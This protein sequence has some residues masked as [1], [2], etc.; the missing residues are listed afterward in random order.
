MLKINL[1]LTLRNLLK[2]KAFAFINIAGLA[3]GIAIALLLYLYIRNELSFDQQQSQKNAIYRLIFNA[4]RDGVEEKWGCS[5]NIA[6]PVFKNE[7]PE[8]IEQV[9]LV[10]HNFGEDANIRFE[11]KAFYEKNL[12][13]VDSGFC[14]VFDLH[15]VAG[16]ATSSLKKPN[17]IIISESTSKKSMFRS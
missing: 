10:R 14:N 13:F 7:I 11:D 5:P 3:S 12:Y 15:F 8:I 4:K 2:N 6:G 9:R 1:K 16:S 17:S